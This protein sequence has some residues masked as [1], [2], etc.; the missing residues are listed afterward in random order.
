LLLS[1]FVIY[2]INPSIGKYLMPIALNIGFGL[3][4][5]MSLLQAKKLNAPA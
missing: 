3:F 1:S 2:L 4:F 5:I